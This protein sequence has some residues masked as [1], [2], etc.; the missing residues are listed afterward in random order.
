MQKGLMRVPF[1]RNFH[2]DAEPLGGPNIRKACL[3]VVVF[4]FQIFQPVGIG[5]VR[6]AKYVTPQVITRFRKP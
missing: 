6:S 4:G 1:E 3:K 2:P 5:Y